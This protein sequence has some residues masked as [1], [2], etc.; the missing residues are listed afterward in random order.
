MTSVLSTC[1]VLLSAVMFWLQC[2]VL[3][4]LLIMTSISEQRAAIHF[5]FLL[6]ESAAKSVLILETAYEGD[7]MEKT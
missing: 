1:L 2:F 6:G 5:S 3:V 7:A 4:S